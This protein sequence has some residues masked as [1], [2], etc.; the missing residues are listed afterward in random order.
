MPFAE[1]PVVWSG[2]EAWK[3]PA[4]DM[5]GIAE[6]LRSVIRQCLEVDPTRR[7]TAG[8]VAASLV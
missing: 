6:P 2:P 4:I 3:L 5:N 7:P 1:P 8:D